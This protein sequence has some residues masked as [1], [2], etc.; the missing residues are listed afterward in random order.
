MDVVPLRI[1]ILS[2]NKTS[3]HFILSFVSSSLLRALF[4]YPTTVCIH[5]KN[6]GCTLMFSMLFSLFAVSFCFVCHIDN[7]TGTG[8]SKRHITFAMFLLFFYSN[9][10]FAYFPWLLHLRF[11]FFHFRIFHSAHIIRAIAFSNAFAYSECNVKN[12][13]TSISCVALHIS[14]LKW[15]HCPNIQMLQCAYNPAQQQSR[16]MNEASFE[17]VQIKPV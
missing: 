6:A 3:H 1:R 10:S 2:H 5:N 4:P 16:M 8:Y 13:F 17:R 14:L 11:R 12:E 15:K 9:Q 7:W